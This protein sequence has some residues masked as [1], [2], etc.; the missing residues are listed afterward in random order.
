MDRRIT[1][2]EYK[3]TKEILAQIRTSKP[4]CK[5]PLGYVNGYPIV[6]VKNGRVCIVVP[7]LKYK[8]TGEVDKTL[9]YPIRYL[10]TYAVKDQVIMSLEDLSTNKAFE[11]FDFNA[12]VGC[13]RHEAVKELTK[14]EYTQ[15]QQELYELY[16]SFA[17][18]LIEKKEYPVSDL[19][20]FRELLGILVEPCLRPFYKTLYPNFYKNCI[21]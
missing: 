21:E 13:F 6:T 19:K 12:P 5:M 16:D 8:K 17:A 20:R 2:S 1:M 3:S 9:V 7:F 11:G 14:A 18:A 10:M 15:K 4:F